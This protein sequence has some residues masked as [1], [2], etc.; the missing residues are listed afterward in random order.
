MIQ[1]FL[2]LL[3]CSFLHQTP[4]AVD[5]ID[6]TVGIIDRFPIHNEAPNHETRMDDSIHRRIL[7]DNKLTLSDKQSILDM[8]NYY[9][10]QV[11]IGNTAN[12]PFAT[13]MN[14]LFWDS[15]LESVAND[16][17]QEC[18]WAH[19]RLRTYNVETLY[20]ENATFKIPTINFYIGEN[21]YATTANANK[22][23]HLLLG[24]YKWYIEFEY[25]NYSQTYQ[26]EA[27]H[28]TALVWADT[29]YVGCAYYTCN[30][31]VRGL[32]SENGEVWT[33][34]GCNYFPGGNYEEFPYLTENIENNEEEQINDL[35]CNNC[36]SDRKQCLKQANSNYTGLCDG[37]MSVW[38]EYCNEGKKVGSLCSETQMQAP[39]CCENGLGVI[40]SKFDENL[41]FCEEN[42][43][44]INS[45]TIETFTQPTLQ[46]IT[47]VPTQ[48]PIVRN[49]DE[50]DASGRNEM[51]NTSNLESTSLDSI[52]TVATQSGANP[53]GMF[54][55]QP[56]TF[57]DIFLFVSSHQKVRCFFCLFDVS[58]FGIKMFRF[59]DKS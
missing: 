3:G 5:T 34:F 39:N 17:V 52:E 1:L 55:L 54:I 35:I 48:F 46:P 29:R 9:R 41:T 47:N 40:N 58:C 53:F 12:Q 21:L 33:I 8:H 18:T 15:A 49:T 37:C 30:D 45:Q 23:S 31:G 59:G 42:F 50:Q 25:Y 32:T 14:S 27:A 6:S 51:N 19:N 20:F 16:W 57:S 7:G 43:Y 26:N 56:S 24:I 22:L 36:D 28:Y 13:N 2:V 4:F 10:S 44:H 11:S 38:Y